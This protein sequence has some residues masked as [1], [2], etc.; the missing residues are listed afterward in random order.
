MCLKE[1]VL[2]IYEDKSP[3][4]KL[5][6]TMPLV[7]LQTVIKT[8]E[9][10][11]T[12]ILP[13]IET[14]TGLKKLLKKQAAKSKFNKVQGSLVIARWAS[15]QGLNAYEIIIAA[16]SE[17]ESKEWLMRLQ[18]AAINS[19]SKRFELNM[20]TQ[21]L[22]LPLSQRDS[23][24]SVIS[25]PSVGAPESIGVTSF[26][27]ASPKV[28]ED[29]FQS[30]VPEIP[31]SKTIS[32]KADEVN[33]V[34]AK[35]K[36][37]TTL[38]TP[39]SA[40]KAKAQHLPSYEMNYP[41]LDDLIATEAHCELVIT[42]LAMERTITADSVAWATVKEQPEAVQL[43]DKTVE[44]LLEVV[45]L[46]EFARH[47]LRTFVQNSA[48]AIKTTDQVQRS[49]EKVALT[50]EE[51]QVNSSELELAPEIA[52]LLANVNSSL[53]ILRKTYRYTTLRRK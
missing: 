17:D 37:Q 44:L 11:M 52:K 13:R 4:S 3:K 49:V 35:L 25:I 38:G 40:R 34:A 22:I 48:D 42:I 36:S 1:P 41:S 33:Q 39:E 29:P 50:L 46:F 51:A 32:R 53:E 10:I 20:S 30:V 7:H 24:L 28:S 43:R 6:A 16:I 5:L 26:D 23:I 2:S 19:G 45:N 27:E 12:D 21:S 31:I 8:T 18:T 9:T 14:A 15:E 47:T